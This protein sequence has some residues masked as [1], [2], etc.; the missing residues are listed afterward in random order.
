MRNRG[1]QAFWAMHVE[2]MKWS[3]MVVREYAAALRLSPM[4][5]ANGA[6]RAQSRPARRFFSDEQKL[7]IAMESELPGPTVSGV[8]RKHAIVTGLLFRGR[9]RSPW[10]KR[11]ARSLC[12]S[13]LPMT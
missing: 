5:C 9:V 10:H 4:R 2:A 8:A 7:A 12:P 3:G 6:P 1:T 13:P 11:N